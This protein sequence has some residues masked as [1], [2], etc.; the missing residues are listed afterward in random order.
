MADAESIGIRDK[1]KIEQLTSQVIERLEQQ[2]TLP[3]MEDLVLKKH[4][5]QKRLVAEAEIRA[6]LKEILASEEPA[7][8]EEFKPEPE[9]QT[10]EKLVIPDK[11]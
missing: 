4:Y 7:R 9:T 10:E 11:P 2:Q 5:Q 1:K 8:P 6:V 3:G